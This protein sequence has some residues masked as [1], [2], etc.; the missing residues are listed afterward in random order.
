M[1]TALTSKLRVSSC[2]TPMKPDYDCATS[3][4]VDT[5]GRNFHLVPE[6]SKED[7]LQSVLFKY[8]FIFIYLLGCPGSQ[9]RHS[10]FSIFVLW[11][12]G[13]LVVV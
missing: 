1:C 4:W 5:E 12:G 3:V 10:R 8:L 6:I 13:F 7:C 11:Y 9:L 2:L